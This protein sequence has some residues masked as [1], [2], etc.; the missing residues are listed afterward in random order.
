MKL[1]KDF[2]ILIIF[3]K[4]FHSL[5]RHKQKLLPIP[6]LFSLKHP[7]ACKNTLT[8]TKGWVAWKV[9]ELYQLDMLK[10]CIDLIPL[11]KGNILF[12]FAFSLSNLITLDILRRISIFRGLMYFRQ[13]I[14][15]FLNTFFCAL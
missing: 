8:F 13:C 6:P 5:T 2:I 7:K 3:H 10:N 9:L 15:I 4:I 11:I 12:I 1:K 14:F